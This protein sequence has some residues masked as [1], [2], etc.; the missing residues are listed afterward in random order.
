MDVAK[1]LDNCIIKLGYLKK[2]LNKV[3]RSLEEECM[4]KIEHLENDLQNLRGGLR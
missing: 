3:K 1:T 4:V 2:E